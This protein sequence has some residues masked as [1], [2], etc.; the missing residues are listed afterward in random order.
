MQ[1]IPNAKKVLLRSYSQQAQA[2]ALALV[3]GYQMLPDR[4]QDAVPSSVVMLVACVVLVL[5][6]IGRLIEQPELSAEDG[7]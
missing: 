7:T 3:G 1:W 5:G 6:M 2:A 4:L